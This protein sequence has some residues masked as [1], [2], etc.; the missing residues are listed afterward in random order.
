MTKIIPSEI[1]YIIANARLRERGAQEDRLA[2][3]DVESVLEVSQTS[4]LLLEKLIALLDMCQELIAWHLTLPRKEQ[5][6]CWEIMKKAYPI[7]IARNS[8]KAE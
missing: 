7:L 4:V 2:L 1:V 8:Q 6:E 5:A 3:V